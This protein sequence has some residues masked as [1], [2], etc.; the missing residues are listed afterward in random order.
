MNPVLAADAAKTIWL[1]EENPA[2]V[3]RSDTA[4]SGLLG[5]IRMIRCLGAATTRTPSSPRAAI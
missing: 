1:G 4:F 3:I 5:M 2:T